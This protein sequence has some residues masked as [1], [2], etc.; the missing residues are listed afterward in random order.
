[1]YN[2]VAASECDVGPTNCSSESNT[3]S[4]INIPIHHTHIDVDLPVLPLEHTGDDLPFQ[5][6]GED[7]SL[8]DTYMHNICETL[9]LEPTTHT[10]IDGDAETQLPEDLPHEPSQS[11]LSK[12]DCTR[13]S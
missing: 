5:H 7:V 13:L 11:L 12:V 3:Q 4:H 10:H 2:V 8:E 6:H 9:P 1:M